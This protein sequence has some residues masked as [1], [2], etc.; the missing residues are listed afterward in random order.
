M[1]ISLLQRAAKIVS[2]LRAIGYQ[3]LAQPQLPRH[4]PPPRT[5]L[6]INNTISA[7]VVK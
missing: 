7:P 4:P 5:T 2:A 1:M 6:M 3:R